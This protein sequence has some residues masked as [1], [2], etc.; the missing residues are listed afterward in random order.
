MQHPVPRCQAL[1]MV[2]PLVSSHS[3]FAVCKPS[4]P[5]A[6]VQPKPWPQTV[7]LPWMGLGLLGRLA[8]GNHAKGEWATLAL[9]RTGT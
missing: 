2:H 1:P 9:L 3:M 6:H 5:C 7:K 8:N 4:N